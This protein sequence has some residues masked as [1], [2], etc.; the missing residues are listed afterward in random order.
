MAIRSRPNAYKVVRFILAFF[1]FVASY[2][3]IYWV[4]FSTI[5]VL[6]NLP[7]IQ[8]NVISLSISVGIGVLVW[9]KTE[10]ISN[11]KAKYIILGGIIT[12]S[13]GFILGFF[14]PIIINP[15]SGQGP[16]LGIFITGPLGFLIGLVGG[17]I[18]WFVK[19][20]PKIKI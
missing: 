18:Y 20:K 16:L 6:K 9:K 5:Q 19:I 17:G 13:I 4:P 11:G 12:G 2:L 3:Y 14:G 10:T 1:S 8:A 15:S 7:A